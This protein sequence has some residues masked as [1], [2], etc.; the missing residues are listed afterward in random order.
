MIG[1]MASIARTDDHGV[2][3]RPLPGDRLGG[4]LRG[5]YGDVPALPQDM[6]RLLRTLD[7]PLRGH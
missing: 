4:A 2:V 6:L 1:E 5:A 7:Q 3:R